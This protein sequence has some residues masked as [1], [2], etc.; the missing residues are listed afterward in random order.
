MPAGESLSTD[1]FLFV[2]RWVAP[3]HEAWVTEPGERLI[4]IFRLEG[5]STPTLIHTGF[6]QV[7]D[8][9]ESLEIDPAR[10]R[11]YANTWH[12]ATV[13]I[14]LDS[15]LIVARWTNG[16][17]GARGLTLDA[18]HGFAFVGCEEGRAVALDVV[19]DGRKATR[20]A[21]SRRLVRS[22][23]GGCPRAGHP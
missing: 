9:P 12:D 20:S 6:I 1:P 22:S 4:E 21:R 14:D 16:C 10:R 7:P 13:A 5:K 8:G 2:L 17:E 19:H 3:L 23:A 15:R 11:A 18:E